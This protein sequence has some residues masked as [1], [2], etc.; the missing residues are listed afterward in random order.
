MG[1]SRGKGE[2]VI[3]GRNRINIY[4]KV[5]KGIVYE[6][7]EEKGIVVGVGVVVVR[8]VGVGVRVFRGLGVGV[9][10]G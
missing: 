2:V 6:V 1:K 8:V 9:G 4:L 7:E 3:G 10:E 5:G